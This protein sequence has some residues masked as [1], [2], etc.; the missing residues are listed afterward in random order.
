MES[1]LQNPT[2]AAPGITPKGN[3]Q[4][5]DSDLSHFVRWNS[6]G[7]PKGKPSRRLPLAEV[8]GYAERS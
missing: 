5:R 1:T 8:T 6:E 7:L 2:L 3:P 4:R